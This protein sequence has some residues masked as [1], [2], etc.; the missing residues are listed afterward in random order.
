MAT[1]ET[2]GG[3][4][5][6]PT[7]PAPSPSPA[8]SP[9]PPAPR[10]GGGGTFPAPVTKTPQRNTGTSRGG[11]TGGTSDWLRTLFGGAS[12]R[13]TS[14]FWS[15][16]AQRSGAHTGVDYGAAYGTQLYAPVSG[17]VVRAGFDGAYGKVVMVQMPSGNYVMFAH[18]SSINVRVGQTI[19]AGTMFG[20][21]GNTGNSTGPHL[22]IEVRTKAS[23]G[24]F[25]SRESWRFLNPVSYFNQNAGS[26]NAKKSGGSG[27]G[28]SGGSSGGGNS[29]G[30]SGT[31]ANAGVDSGGWSKEEIYQ[32][33]GSQFGDVKTLLAL[34]K[35]LTKGAEGKSLKWAIDELVR[36]QITDPSI[37]L[38]YLRQTAFF[39]KYGAEV[40]ERLVL[41]RQQ[42]GVA[43]RNIEEATAQIR[44][45][46]NSLGIQLPDDELRKIA[47]RSW[48]F[49][50]TPQQE[51]EAIAK[52]AETVLEGGQWS[53]TVESLAAFADDYGVQFTDAMHRQLKKDFLAG[54]GA[55]GIQDL[56]REQAAAK[57]AVLADRINAGESVRSIT[58]AYFNLAAD[59]LELDVDAID[60]DDP[61]FANG[62][63]FTTTGQDG[64]PAMKTLA[65]FEREI[66][67]DSRWMKT[68]NAQDELT[69]GAYGIL[70]RFGMVG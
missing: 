22:H 42:P 70:Q 47:R 36:K 29:S 52:S 11:G 51:Q 23:Q 17:K 61:L 48:V 30:P 21:V 8:P 59:R 4:Y 27:G 33:L 24:K 46:M 15:T 7:R 62:K 32:W 14:N 63:A 12:N 55:A 31:G 25:G 3:A 57:Y 9:V 19:S 2:G 6:P 60:W 1:T 16:S 35:Q 44:Q 37:A 10:R 20:R 50:W 54:K 45:S 40:A 49:G 69:N 67:S 34:D 56:L 39:K 28:S 38:T 13:Q 41:E 65:D 5:V 26:S 53:E 58:D 64:Q 18:L 43:N 66:R 68:T